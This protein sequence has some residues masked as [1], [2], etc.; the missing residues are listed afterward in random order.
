MTDLIAFHE[1]ARIEMDYSLLETT[2]NFLIM[3]WVLFPIKNAI[4][5]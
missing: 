4:A 5:L 2:V 1:S 3:I